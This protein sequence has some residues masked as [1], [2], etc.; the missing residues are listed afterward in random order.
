MSQYKVRIKALL[1]LYILLLIVY[2]LCKLVFYWFNRL[3]FDAQTPNGL[4]SIFL[5]GIR[6]D[7]S[8][9][10]FT[11]LV[12]TLLFL[13]PFGKL[14]KSNWYNTI[15]KVLF[16]A[17]NL[18]FISLN[19]VDVAY[20]PFVQK[21]LQ[22]DALLFATGDK[23][24]EAFGMIPTFLMQ[25]W[26]LLVIFFGITYLLNA[27]YN[28]VVKPSFAANKQYV[29]SFS[30]IAIFVLMLGMNVLG[31]RGGLQLRPISI[32]DATNVS[33]VTNAPFVLNSSFSLIRTW[34]KNKIREKNYFD[35]INNSA[36]ESP[37][38]QFNK[39]TIAHDSQ[40]NVII[41]MVE[42][43]S[44]QYLS[45]FGGKGKTPFLDS[46]MHQSLVFTNGFANA[47]ESVQGVPAVL[48]SLPSW[49]DE[50]Y[51][52]SRYST[53]KVQSLASILKQY[54]YKTSFF[55]G[56]AIGSMGFYSFTKSAGFDQYYGR[57]DYGNEAH[58]DGSWG[59]W[60]HHFLPFMTKQLSNTKEPFLSA[61][62]TLNTH[63]PFV[64][65]KEFVVA[66]PSK[67][68]PILNSVQYIDHTLAQFFQEIKDEKWFQNTLFVITADHTGPN[69]TNKRTTI[70]DFSIPVIFYKPNSNLKGESNIVMGQIDIMP[71][72]LHLLGIKDTIFSFGKNIFDHQCLSRVI[73]YKMGIYQY[74]NDRFHLYFDGEKSLALY[75]WKKDTFL[76]SNLIKDKQYHATIQAI[77]KDL[78]KSIQNYHHT[79]IHNK[80]TP[81]AF[82]Q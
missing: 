66:Q 12:F 38:K 5:H 23:G 6:Y 29:L 7:L 26:S 35:P 58:F 16:L 64:V 43:L 27:I 34:Q 13:I 73:N 39:D 9:I 50:S 65:P 15:L 20:F 11:N 32:L 62:L 30:V 25:N 1:F 48:A 54:D 40:M 8:A 24:T 41:I 17:I 57:E 74:T 22:N 76:K 56:A 18:F 59:I 77:E 71:S 70:E 81:D 61:I 53:N 10:L 42:S 3:D 46:L 4:G 36:C 49:M 55:H 68:Y 31:I 44:K 28:F 69:T 78:K 80:M 72:I 52:F 67:K 45:Y 47:R 82:T 33:G 21:R 75:D 79:I 2:T 51:I 14:G 60:D 37:I 19:L 63:H